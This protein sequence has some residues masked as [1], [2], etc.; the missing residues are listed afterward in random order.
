[1]GSNQSIEQSHCHTSTPYSNE[2]TPTNDV[3]TALNQGSGFPVDL[4]INS[5]ES[6]NNI[7]LSK[8]NNLK[9][10]R[11]LKKKQSNSVIQIS[12]PHYQPIVTIPL[13]PTI[14]FSYPYPCLFR[15]IRVINRN[16]VNQTKENQTQNQN[17]NLESNLNKG[18]IEYVV[19]HSAIY[20]PTLEDE[21]YELRFQCIV[22]KDSKGEGIQ[23]KF[24]KTM[25]LPSIKTKI[26]WVDDFNFI[27]KLQ[28]EIPKYITNYSL[29]RNSNFE[30]KF[31]A[32]VY[33][34][35]GSYW[36]I[37]DDELKE[38]ETPLP[39]KS[40][41]NDRNARKLKIINY[42]ERVKIQDKNL[43]KLK[44]QFPKCPSYVFSLGYR[45]KMG[46]R[47]LLSYHSDL[48]FLHNVNLEEYKY[49]NLEFSKLGYSS[50]IS[51]NKKLNEKHTGNCILYR[52]SKFNRLEPYILKFSEYISSQVQD[53]ELKGILHSIQATCDLLKLD[54]QYLD[55]G[56]RSAL[57]NEFDFRD[58][59]IMRSSI[60][61]DLDE[62]LLV[63]N[64]QVYLPPNKSKEYQDLIQIL[65][66]YI[67]MKF[68]YN[69]WVNKFQQRKNISFIIA[70]DLEY[71]NQSKVYQYI[72]ESFTDNY[73]NQTNSTQITT[74]S[75]QNTTIE[76]SPEFEH[77]IQKVY[78]TQLENQNQKNT[79][80]VTVTP[81]Y[82]E[83]KENIDSSN[84][85]NLND[86]M[87]QYQ[88]IQ[89][90]FPTPFKSTYYTISGKEPE[91]LQSTSNN[92]MLPTS[93]FL[94]VN[95]LQ[96]NRVSVLPKGISF[97][98]PLNISNQVCLLS[99]LEF[100]PNQ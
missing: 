82:Q 81:K 60:E 13:I 21:G 91:F 92:D 85:S 43:L 87:K 65:Q 34:M 50:N 66:I 41:S 57:I 26:E 28:T 88:F 7:N 59:Y 99:E 76:H 16:N 36:L 37:N 35:M 42:R 48:Y 90:P 98:N 73:D 74:N 70:C 24:K 18:Y 23:I 9:E 45:K 6:N 19:S 97:P 30:K 77:Q 94:F 83:Q 80:I 64:L 17:Q 12:F 100:P 31:T 89:S 15:W 39:S 49:W 69:L 47:E 52:R 44:N 78:S 72:T 63:A 46:L 1:M 29:S 75:V 61:P 95:N 68:L 62:K 20:T 51:D 11:K 10:N 56:S 86:E 32:S 84:L 4:K 40:N 55:F 22:I 54:S 2:V 3:N 33:N 38:L 14:S 25:N 67:V 53:S 96:A 27:N 71:S 93:S 79:Q 5:N 8:R 58:L